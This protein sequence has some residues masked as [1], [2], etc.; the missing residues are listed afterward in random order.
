VQGTTQHVNMS[1]IFENCSRLQ[2]LLFRA[3]QEDVLASLRVIAVEEGSSKS[4]FLGK[5][6]DPSQT[7]MELVLTA[8]RVR[9]GYTSPKLHQ[10]KVKGEGEWTRK[11]EF[12]LKSID[13]VMIGTGDSVYFCIVT[14]DGKR[15]DWKTVMPNASSGASSS[16]GAGTAG[17]ANAGGASIAGAGSAATLTAALNG[18]NRDEFLWWLIQLNLAT[19][20]TLIPNNMD[21]YITSQL[22]RWSRC[23][24]QTQTSS[25]LDRP[26]AIPFPSRSPTGASVSQLQ[27]YV[28]VKVLSDGRSPTNLAANQLGTNA[29]ARHQITT[30]PIVVPALSPKDAAL[31]EHTMRELGLTPATLYRAEEA[32]LARARDLEIE[33]TALALELSQGP[34]S[35]LL[36]SL[37]A[38]VFNQTASLNSWAH[39]QDAAMA[40]LRNT[41][42]EIENRAATLAIEDANHTRLCATL[43]RLISKIELPIDAERILNDPP[44]HIPTDAKN[45]DVVTNAGTFPHAAGSPQTIALFGCSWASSPLYA[46]HRSALVKIVAAADALYVTLRNIKKLTKH[47]DP[48]ILKRSSAKPSAVHHHHHHLTPRT[49][50][51]SKLAS[52]RSGGGAEHESSELESLSTDDERIS[53]PKSPGSQPPQIAASGTL[54][55][56]GRHTRKPPHGTGVSMHEAAWR[57]AGSDPLSAMAL[58]VN[59]TIQRG[60][61]HLSHRNTTQL[62]S[63]TLQFDLTLRGPPDL[64]V[65]PEAEA[66]AAA[67]ERQEELKAKMEIESKRA[68][69]ESSELEDLD[70]TTDEEVSK[71]RPA[72]ASSGAKTGDTKPTLLAAKRIAMRKKRRAGRYAAPLGHLAAVHSQLALCENLRKNFVA[73][74]FKLLKQRITDVAEN[75]L[76]LASNGLSNPSFVALAGLERANT[77]FLLYAPLL[78][79]LE[80][81][82]P[83]IRAKLADAYVEAW[84]P[85]YDSDIRV[86]FKRLKPMYE[87]APPAECRLRESPETRL[88]GSNAGA[89]IAALASAAVSGVEKGEAA[90]LA[91]LGLK[92]LSSSSP[93]LSAA[94]S[95][96]S[97]ESGVSSV[98]SGGG[99]SI[100]DLAA[101]VPAGSRVA[102]VSTAA[103]VAAAAVIVAR[104]GLEQAAART[105]LAA[106]AAAQAGSA[107]ASAVAAA[108]A[109]KS[110]MESSSE[111]QLWAQP[112]HAEAFGEAVERMLSLCRSMQT[113]FVKLFCTLKKK[114]QTKPKDKSVV[115]A[116][117]PKAKSAEEQD[118]EEEVEVD[119]GLTGEALLDCYANAFLADQMITKLSTRITHYL[120]KFAFVSADAQNYFAIV[121]MIVAAERAADLAGPQSEEGPLLAFT[122]IMSYVCGELKKTWSAF[123]DEEIAWISSYK[124]NPKQGGV[125]PPIS[126]LPVFVARLEA[127]CRPPP[128]WRCRPTV[129]DNAYRQLGTTLINWLEQ[130]ASTNEKYEKVVLMESSH[131][132]YAA[133]LALDVNAFGPT[134]ERALVTFHLSRQAYTLW[135]I[136]YEMPQIWSYW[137]RLDK[138]LSEAQT[139]PSDVALLQ[140]LGKDDLRHLLSTQYNTNKLMDHFHEIVVRLRRHLPYNF[141]LV[142]SVFELIRDEFVRRARKFDRQVAEC[143][144]HE[145]I[146]ITVEDIRALFPKALPELN[147]A[148]G[149]LVSIP[150]TFSGP[151]TRL[152]STTRGA[153]ADPPSRA[154]RLFSR[155]GFGSKIGSSS[156]AAAASSGPTSPTARLKTKGTVI[157]EES[158]LSDID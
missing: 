97:S 46:K 30:S 42:N 25:S 143:Y 58:A 8:Q 133:L 124:I 54:L 101:L 79:R 94:A 61:E 122:Q 115:E 16:D 56:A 43:E 112:P 28:I 132:L 144:P 31:L 70:T 86:Y 149:S 87:H 5:R 60:G 19:N 37:A 114:K 146:N 11:V 126:R 14:N 90:G 140:G 148:S 44:W 110:S 147:A 89:L 73:H 32:L 104:G 82:E 91:A 106:R 131:F 136:E 85:V 38:I 96:A 41:I 92:P 66:E 134:L 12:P 36:S 7:V 84:R 108:A 67:L 23:I 151:S 71:N 55:A 33:S 156:G 117:G 93:S 95:S 68:E 75:Q 40:A 152:D 13:R 105:V 52:K 127:L 123:I 45:P 74:M 98:S 21:D 65:D 138:E 51:S 50:A 135:H 39:R 139:A 62:L 145:K 57:K 109:A 120:A 129:V 24:A 59:S 150:T 34:R 78:E 48:R 63:E 125:L 158:E 99:P 157:Q 118:S 128:A 4:R 100:A 80:R 141:T 155:L 27:G 53:K 3:T 20:R 153:Q 142:L 47:P 1:T 2:S 10:L 154:S 116:N 29:G 137:Q 83:G 26:G 49:L 76:A 119:R 17:A 103:S 35:E 81:L 102:V 64:D 18:S 72:T 22:T 107:A 69:P 9:E 111:H 130:V 121:P 6:R 77:N 88:E 113:N 15:Y